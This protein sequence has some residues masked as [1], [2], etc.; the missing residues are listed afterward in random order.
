MNISIHTPAIARAA[1]HLETFTD[2]NRTDL[3]KFS[4]EKRQMLLETGREHSRRF[5]LIAFGHTLGDELDV[6]IAAIDRMALDKADRAASIQDRMSKRRAA[7][8]E[9]EQVL[10]AEME[11]AAA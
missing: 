9:R 4:P 6:T 5:D 10:V 7:E 1:R 2:I 3:S 11:A 8:A